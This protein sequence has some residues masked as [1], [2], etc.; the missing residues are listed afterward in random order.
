LGTLL[1][2]RLEPSTPLGAECTVCAL[3]SDVAIEKTCEGFP[4]YLCEIEVTNL[5]VS[6]S[7]DLVV[8][9]TIPAPLF[10]LGDDCGAGPPAGNVLTWNAP[11]V[12]V[13]GS[14]ICAVQF[15]APPDVSGEVVNVVD[16][17]GG[18]PDPDV[19]NNT[20]SALI[21]LGTTLD[22]PTLGAGGVA[23]LILALGGLGFRR[24]RTGRRP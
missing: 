18:V 1:D 10:W 11:P 21:T 7:F 9:D 12:D 24:L 23:L 20:A 14:V 19:G 3:S 22:I 16:V 17:V 8:T 4:S 13:G 2:W 5:G 15:G 6:P